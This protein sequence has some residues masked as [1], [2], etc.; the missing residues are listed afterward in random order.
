MNPNYALELLPFA[1]QLAVPPWVDFWAPNRSGSDEADR[2]AG[3]V[4]FR[5]FLNV[6]AG[7]TGAETHD[8]YIQLVTTPMAGL[9]PYNLLSFIVG[10]MQGVGPMEAAFLEALAAK[11][12]AGR[13]PPSM[14]A[15]EEDR[16]AENH[17]LLCLE[18]CRG[19]GASAL[20]AAEL[21]EVVNGLYEVGNPSVFV[22][23]ICAAATNGA[24]N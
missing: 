16:T 3:A 15:T 24:L 7:L 23:T 10:S 19:Y 2:N 14:A 1:R 6:L 11:A 20:L 22:W 17:A 9:P 21:A 4:H 13:S 8:F 12:A 18:I 5:A